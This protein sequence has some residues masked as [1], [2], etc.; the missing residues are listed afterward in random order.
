MSTFDSFRL[1][2]LQ[3]L[4]LRC[5]FPVSDQLFSNPSYESDNTL[6]NVSPHVVC[7]NK[8]E[9][10]LCR[11]FTARCM[12]EKTVPSQKLFIEDVV[13]RL[14]LLESSQN[15][16][17]EEEITII[18]VSSL[19]SFRQRFVLPLPFV[20]LHSDHLITGAKISFRKC[21]R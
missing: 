9:K 7:S 19:T 4:H 12:K 16:G 11:L 15:L 2:L 17:N 21:L 8:Y 5:V 3:L 13:T 18:E 20:F 1:V 10:T 6:V 14:R